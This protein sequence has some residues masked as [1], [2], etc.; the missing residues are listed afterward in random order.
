MSTPGTFGD[1]DGPGQLR[2]E[3]EVMAAHEGTAGTGVPAP[4]P[5]HGM[6]DEAKYGGPGQ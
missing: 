2:H 6:S 1:I 5:D 4:A 3:A